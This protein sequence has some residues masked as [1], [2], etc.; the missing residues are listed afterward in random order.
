LTNRE[1]S[2]SGSARLSASTKNIFALTRF[3]P[4]IFRIKYLDA[5][6]GADHHGA[7]N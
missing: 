1:V 3:L 2:R 4:A 6:E 5:T 7:G